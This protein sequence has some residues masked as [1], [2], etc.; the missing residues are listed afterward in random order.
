MRFTGQM[1]EFHRRRATKE[2]MEQGQKEIR[3]ADE[4]MKTEAERGVR[5]LYKTDLKKNLRMV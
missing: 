2:E 5:C 3:L 4:R 1:S